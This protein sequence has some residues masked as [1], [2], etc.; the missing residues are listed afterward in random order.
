MRG[1]ILRDM[2][3]APFGTGQFGV[4]QLGSWRGVLYARGLGLARSRRYWGA[5]W[6]VIGNCLHYP[7]LPRKY[8]GLAY[9]TIPGFTQ[10]VGNIDV[11]IVAMEMMAWF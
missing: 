2:C 1:E 5:V 7:S 6:A 11:K 10:V 3:S 8:T 4:L 9:V